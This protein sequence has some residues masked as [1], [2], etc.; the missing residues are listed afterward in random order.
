MEKFE[1]WKKAQQALADAEE[2]VGMKGTKAGYQNDI[3]TLG[4]VPSP[5]FDLCG[6]QYVGGKNYWE[7]PRDFNDAFAV[8][9]RASFDQLAADALIILREK[10]KQALIESEGEIEMMRSALDAAWTLTAGRT[11]AIARKLRMKGRK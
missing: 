7:S 6:Q 4:S 5:K 9:I 3:F 2:W 10:E 8:A 11:R 1:A